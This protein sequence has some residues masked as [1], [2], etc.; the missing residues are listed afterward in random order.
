MLPGDH[1]VQGELYDVNDN[2]LVQLDRI[3]GVPHLYVRETLEVEEQSTYEEYC[4]NAYLW[5][6]N[7]PRQEN[8]R[9][10]EFDETTNTKRWVGG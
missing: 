2:T 8:H 1:Y 3:E 5:A 9:D 7:E 4:A 10:I 6:V